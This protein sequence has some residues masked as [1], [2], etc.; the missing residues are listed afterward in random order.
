MPPILRTLAAGVAT[1][2][3]LSLTASLALGW[4][5]D[6]TV[7]VK[8]GTA[9]GFLG[10][11]GIVSDGAGGSLVAY[12]ESPGGSKVSRLDAN[13]TVRWTVSVIALPS[14]ISPDAPVITTDGAGGA[15]VAFE[16]MSQTS[17]VWVQ[18]V[19]ASGQR[20]WGDDGIVVVDTTDFHPWPSIASDGTGGAIV[21]WTDRRTG[22]SRMMAQRVAGNGTML[23][24]RYGVPL[25]NGKPDQQPNA[26]ARADGRGG[27]LFAWGD[28]LGPSTDIRVQRVSP[29]GTAMWGAGGV[30]VRNAGHPEVSPSLASDGQGGAYVAW[31]ESAGPYLQH[32]DDNGALMWGAS[33]LLLSSFAAAYYTDV[34][35]DGEGGAIVAWEAGNSPNDRIRVQRVGSTG[36]VQ[37]STNGVAMCATTDLMWSPVVTPDGSGGA[38]VSWW[39]GPS[40]SVALRAQRVGPTGTPMWTTDG[41]TFASGT[42]SKWAQAAIP[43]GTGGIVAAFCDESRGDGGSSAQRVDGWGV[44]GG[45]PLITRFRDAVNDQGGYGHLQWSKSP[46]DAGSPDP[47]ASY[48]L[49]RQV[50]AAAAQAA[51]ARGARWIGGDDQPDAAPRGAYATTQVDGATWYW[52]VLGGVSATGAAS[53]EALVATACDSIV[54]YTPK[55]TVYMVMARGATGGFWTSPPDSGYSIDNLAPG[56]PDPVSGTYIP[57]AFATSLSWGPVSAPDLA[58]YR[59]YRGGTVTF[60]IGPA[61]YAGFTTDI[62]Y[63]DYAGQPYFYKV[64]A[65]DIHGNTGPSNLIVPSGIADA[66][67]T[68]PRALALSTPVPN[69]LRSSTTL[70]LALPAAA[71][72]TLAVFDQQGRRVRMLADGERTAGVHAIAWDGRGD[73]G[74]V[75]PSGLYFAQLHSGGRTLTRRIIAVR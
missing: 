68:L 2:A 62:S 4:P 63:L 41:V 71:R 56:Q 72:V 27:A 44:L 74:R 52:E 38:V 11:P 16:D 10:S 46:I 3:I 15:I 12:Y 43:D 5:N 47:I 64:L 26:I 70:T 45:D 21:V 40:G 36:T 49:F 57:A 60:T 1:L 39:I 48:W 59:I 75:V 28:S 8:L 66:G 54:G 32:V 42:V 35:P 17:S 53:Y 34:A 9:A 65:V 67:T 23:W 20:L 6:P 33:G 50:P 29:T 22:L 37:W 61:T 51:L 58:G 7:N 24:T 18:R 31:D 13:G 30:L 25:S 55:R 19:S 14:A 73:D 69:P